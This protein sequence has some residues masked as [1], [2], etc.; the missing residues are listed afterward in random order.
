MPQIMPIKDLKDTSYIS[1]MCHKAEEPIY[2]TKNGYGDMVVMSMEL[3]ES[4]QRKWN[5][6]SDIELSEQQIKEEKTKDARKA[7]SATREKYGL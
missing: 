2:I 7:L 1:E 6:Y 5:M 3:F 4:L